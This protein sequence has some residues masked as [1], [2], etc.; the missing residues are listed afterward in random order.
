MGAVGLNRQYLMSSRSLSINQ[1][2]FI[3]DNL[4][5]FRTV[6]CIRKQDC[7]DEK[8]VIETCLG[9]KGVISVLIVLD[10]CD[11]TVPLNPPVLDVM[12]QWLR[13]LLH[14]LEVQ[15]LTLGLEAG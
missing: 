11:R 5:S 6:M 2:V 8:H 14:I 12:V 3:A 15:G 9:W 4:K 13:F 7:N 10:V 1:K